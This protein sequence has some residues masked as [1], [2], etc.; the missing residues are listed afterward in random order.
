MKINR[1]WFVFVNVK[2]NKK[3]WLIWIYLKKKEKFK[4]FKKF[5]R[6]WIILIFDNNWIIQ[7]WNMNNKMKMNE[8]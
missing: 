5:K 4:F 7:E 2:E 1:I 3:D 8:E 6:N